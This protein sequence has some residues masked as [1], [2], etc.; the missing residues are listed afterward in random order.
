MNRG[1]TY[2]KQI[3]DAIEKINA[4]TIDGKELL[5]YIQQ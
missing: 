5:T 3:L 2:T 4:Y 1:Q